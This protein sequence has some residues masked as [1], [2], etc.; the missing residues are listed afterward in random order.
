MLL[1][2]SYVSDFLNVLNRSPTS[3]TCHQHIRSPTSVTDIDVTIYTAEP[4]NVNSMFL[5][6]ISVKLF[7]I[8]IHL[9]FNLHR[10]G[11][12]SCFTISTIF[13]ILQF[14]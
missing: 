13:T 5:H 10:I 2:F 14:G 8:N 4:K 11:V 7:K 6:F 12:S 1:F 3:Q 9:I